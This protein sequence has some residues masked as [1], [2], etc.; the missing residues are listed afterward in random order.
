MD[1]LTFLL[2]VIH[3]FAILVLL[4]FSSTDLKTI[5]FYFKCIFLELHI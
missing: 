1:V 2:I 3:S 4:L 5:N